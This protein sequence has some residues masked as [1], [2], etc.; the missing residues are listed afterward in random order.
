ML[1]IMETLVKYSKKKTIQE[2]V[3]GTFEHAGQREGEAC[4]HFGEES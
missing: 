1:Q 3:L 4:W 2:T